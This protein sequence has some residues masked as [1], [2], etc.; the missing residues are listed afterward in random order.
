MAKA[1]KADK[2]PEKEP[3]KD[4]ALLQVSVEDFERTRDSVVTGL[5]TLQN[6]V[7]D[8]SRAYIIHTN[9]VLGRAP[10][11]TLE[12]LNLPKSINEN[13]ILGPRP[14]TA[15]AEKSDGAAPEKEKKKKRFHDPNAPKRPLTPYFLYMQTARQI[16]ANDLGENAKPGEVSAE[17]TKRWTEMS[18]NEKNMWKQ[19]YTQN[20]EAYHGRMAL[21]K[22]GEDWRAVDDAAAAQLAQET[23]AAI[24]ADDDDEDATHAEVPPKAPTPPKSPK[25]NKRRKTAKDADTAAAKAK[26]TPI[27][28][29]SSAA[30]TPIPVPTPAAADAKEPSPDKK[31]KKSARKTKA[32]LQKE[33][34]EAAVVAEQA[35]P[36]EVP[37]E[38]VKKEKE[39]KPKR[40]R[41]SD[42]IEA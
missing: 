36:A 31:K 21:Y 6:A 9:T 11:Q 2:A 8:L 10:N 15:D 26:E 34:D 17:G 28:V 1:K 24:E 19:V 38:S 22:K 39:K 33:K 25:A 30:K 14:T 7:Q 20:L 3:T 27:P 35:E 40:K 18:E 13:G 42:A 37:V 4:S 41:K 12:L 16:I 32:E 29:P 23:G 5:A